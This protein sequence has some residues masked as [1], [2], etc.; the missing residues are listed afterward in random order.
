MAV[1]KELV[2]IVGENYVFDELEN[3]GSYLKDF[4]SE[5]TFSLKPAFLPRF[6]VQ[7]S[8]SREIQEILKLANIYN[9]PIIPCSSQVHFYGLTVPKKE[10]GIILDLRRMN[11]ISMA[12]AANRTIKIEAGVTWEQFCLELKRQRYRSMIPLLPHSL[13]SVVT[14][15]L[16]RE[17]PLSPVYEYGEPLLSMEIVWPTSEIFRTGSASTPGFPK[18]IAR[19]VNPHG[20]GLDWFRLLTGA[21]GTMGIVTW[22]ILK[23][24]LPPPTN[25]LFIIPFEKIQDAVKFIY[26]SQRLMLGD[27]CFLLNNLNAKIILRER[28]EIKKLSEWPWMLILVLSGSLRRPEEKI[29]YEK[30]ALKE[31][32]SEFKVEPIPC[33]MLS[34]EELVSTFRNPWPNTLTYWKHLLKGYCQ[35]IFFITT[36]NKVKLFIEVLAEL[37]VKHDYDLKNVGCY[38]QPIERGRACHCEFNFYYKQDEVDNVRNLYIDVARS[39]QKLGAFYTR[40]YGVLADIVYSEAV[41]YA[42]LL[43]RLKKLLDPKGIMNPGSLCF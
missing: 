42:N 20:P 30:K 25:E 12:D 14:S 22:A 18:S 3:L 8:S 13:K 34:V 7:P 43:K 40:P 33:N 2:K 6:I 24:E 38:V 1:K 26:K 32:L 37:A 41:D 39:F 28:A 16:E 31:L 29:M 10:G 17:V 5:P 23:V 27:E 11:R 9:T 21:Q 35:D 19:G 15:W 4:S 36:L